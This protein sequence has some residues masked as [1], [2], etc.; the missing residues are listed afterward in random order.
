MRFKT[1]PSLSKLDAELYTL[2]HRG[3]P[4]DEAFYVRLCADGKRILELGC[5]AGRLL[6]EL[7]REDA[8][9]VGLEFDAGLRSMA[10]SALKS[11]PRERRARVEVI[12]GDMRAFAF[13]EQ[14]DRILLPYNGLYC[15]LSRAEVLACLKCVR[16]HLAPSGIF[17]FDVW[18]ADPFHAQTEELE[19]ET[20]DPILAINHA[21]KVWD[22]YETTFWHRTRQRLD[23]RYSY[24]PRGRGQPRQ[25]EIPQRYLL[26]TELYELLAQADL[27]VQRIA[28]DFLGTRVNRY[29]ERLVIQ[30]C[31]EKD[32]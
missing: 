26:R 32:H 23:A 28:G 11:L 2:T 29:S 4:G 16:A 25:I 1:R 31:A 5:G 7:A 3:N 14:F 17:A 24:E 22:V 19:E 21:R 30:A 27:R 10:R 9:L 18:R 8:M 6:C 12:A 13:K 15:L 20:Q